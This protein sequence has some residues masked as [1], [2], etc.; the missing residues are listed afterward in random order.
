M[1][2][3][4]GIDW[5]DLAVSAG[6]DLDLSGIDLNDPLFSHGFVRNGTRIIYVGA[7]EAEKLRKIIGLLDPS[8]K[9][10]RVPRRDL[11]AAGFLQELV[12]EAPP[13]LARA[14][15]I[16]RAL[17]APGAFANAAPPRGFQGT[18]RN[19]QRVGLGWLQFLAEQG[20][21]GCLADDMG[22]GKTVQ[23]L[24]LLQGLKEKAAGDDNRGVGK[25]RAGGAVGA[26]DAQDRAAPS[27]V[28]APVS[29]LRNWEAEAARFTPG[30]R[31]QV[32]HGND[33]PEDA[34]AFREADLV[35]VSYATLRNDQELF[36]QQEWGVLI[37]DEA[38][39]IKNPGTQSFAAVKTLKSRHRFTLTGTPLENSV[40]DLWAQLDFLEP[41]LLGSMQ[42]FRKKFAG[43]GADSS[44]PER[45]RLRRIVRP[46][47]LRR[48]KD[49]V[50]KSL[51]PKEEV[52]LFAEMGTRQKAAYDALKE[53]YRKRI[54]AA[55]RDKG[56]AASGAL[57]FE[58]LLRLRQAACIP[59][60][61]SPSLKGT[62]SAKLELLHGV[63][64]EIM[65][66]GHRVL[67]FS[68][69][70]KTLAVIA[71]TLDHREVRYAYLDGST[72]NRQQV[73]DR[74]QGD[75]SVPLFLLSLK[76]GG[77][78]INLTAADYVVI[79]DPWWNP[80]VERQAVDRSH[81][82]GQQKPVFVYRLITKESI[83]ERI[84]TLQDRKRALAAE[85]I[86]ENPTSLFALGEEELMGLFR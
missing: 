60:H 34:G 3:S 39:S 73:I 43:R 7:E 85:L 62:P 63:L 10:P 11:A 45:E 57:I 84:L 30:L 56:I 1:R 20:L 35:I 78:G 16:S 59:E 4:T 21:N 46:F 54:A 50:E 24:A 13:E 15:E 76:A 48:T 33:R 64:D 82:I 66:E 38:Q 41:G 70:V 42:R 52:R 67:V 49:V 69:F 55:L 53:G 37:L 80:A 47:I 19:Y 68:Q 61:A 14:A 51:P 36:Q 74:F 32:H 81:R 22:L 79:F 75:S 86:E 72:R 12:P 83:E 25:G 5:F 9:S 18:L 29:T 23:A 27:L 44:D 65:S 28:V 31:V 58:G 17:A 6:E 26:N 2:V 77:L 71:S 8:Q 40:I